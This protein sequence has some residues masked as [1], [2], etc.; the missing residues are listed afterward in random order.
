MDGLFRSG[1]RRTRKKQI[2]EM[3]LN[4]NDGKPSAPPLCTDE[5]EKGNKGVSQ[6][7]TIDEQTSDKPV[8]KHDCVQAVRVT[9]EEHTCIIKSNKEPPLRVTKEVLKNK[10]THTGKRV[11]KEV[12]THLVSEGF[13]SLVGV[14]KGVLLVVYR[15][16]L[17]DGGN[18]T[19]P[20]TGQYLSDVLA[21][22]LGT[23]KTSLNRLKKKNLIVIVRYKAG[24]G[25]WIQY[26]LPQI[27]LSQIYAYNTLIGEQK[28]NI[29][30][31]QT[32][33]QTVTTPPVVV[34]SEELNNINKNLHTEELEPYRLYVDT[35]TIA[36]LADLGLFITDADFL[37]CSTNGIS[38]KV[39]AISLA[40][41]QEDLNSGH[42]KK[43]NIR[44]LKAFLRG[45]LKKNCGYISDRVQEKQHKRKQLEESF[46]G[47]FGGDLKFERE[48][49]GKLQ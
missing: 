17:E 25:G 7:H 22:T 32:M 19:R 9:K 42:I 2:E 20:L 4:K 46:I 49:D 38:P 36:E 14:Q 28:G 39:F 29:T 27:V 26:S 43:Q 34:R 44:S 31:P 48:V 35:E 33:S 6:T 37:W 5:R 41:F 30:V 13:E 47:E 8:T 21:V 40:H 23:I 16:M 10:N 18:E 45:S 11:T 24:R 12:P 3:V 15:L 1:K